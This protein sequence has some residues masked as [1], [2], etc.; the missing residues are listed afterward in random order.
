[1]CELVGFILITNHH[2]VVMNRLNLFDICQLH[3]RCSVKTQ[4]CWLRACFSRTEK[5]TY[6]ICN[7]TAV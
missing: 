2:C 1:M 3:G 5:D 6:S 7:S 4:L